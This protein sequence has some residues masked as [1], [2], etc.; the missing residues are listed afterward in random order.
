MKNSQVNVTLLEPNNPT[1]VDLRIATQSKD[2]IKNVKWPLWIWYRFLERKPVAPLKKF[3]KTQT[4]NRR[5]WIK[6]YK[7]WKSKIELIQKT[8]TKGNL[9]MKGLG[10]SLA[11]VVNR[12][13]E[14]EES[15]SSYWRLNRRHKYLKWKKMINQ[16]N[17]WS[18]TFGESGTL[19]KD[20]I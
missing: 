10:S 15:F 4:N 13:Q 14:M 20:H 12:G 16:K 3:R 17:S 1:T 5:E 18:K 6:Q 7:T 8:Q 11:R 2:K 19:W 9:K